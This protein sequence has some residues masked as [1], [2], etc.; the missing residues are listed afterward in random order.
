MS[1]DN[2]AVGG[3]KKPCDND[4]TPC[5]SHVIVS[6]ARVAILFSGGIDS[7]VIAALAD[8][9]QPLLP[10]V[11]LLNVR[12]TKQLFSHKFLAM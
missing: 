5:D 12:K 1:C 6:L 4:L 10:L 8:R 9:Y 7:A 3:A 11:T 2:E